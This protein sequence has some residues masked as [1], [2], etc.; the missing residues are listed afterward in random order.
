MKKRENRN[1]NWT[2]FRTCLFPCRE[3]QEDHELARE[4][5]REKENEIEREK[6]IRKRRLGLRD[7]KRTRE[8]RPGEASPSKYFVMEGGNCINQ[9]ITMTRKEINH[10][11][12]RTRFGMN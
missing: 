4:R 10:D 9:Y 7:K 5:E 6:E 3:R 1:G 11:N 2:Y 12:E 8:V